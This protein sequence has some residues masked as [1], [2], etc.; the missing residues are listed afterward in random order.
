MNDQKGCDDKDDKIV[1][2]ALVDSGD[3]GAHQLAE[4]PPSYPQAQGQ[5]L[6][7]AHPPEVPTASAYP[8]QPHHT[9]APFRTLHIMYENWCMNGI[10]IHDTDKSTLLYTLKRHLRTPH[11]TL[12]SASSAAT[13]GTAILHFHTSRV[14]I[15]VN[16]AAVS[17][18]S[19]GFW[20]KSYK[21]SSPAL[22]GATVTWKCNNS[23]LD[24]VCVDEQEI[25]IARFRYSNWSLKK[26]GSFEILGPKAGTVQLT[27]EMLVTGLAL[28]VLCQRL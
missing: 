12:E 16:E 15:T 3:R 10:R 26:C 5:A 25:A 9:Q 14:D 8:P 2:K 21:W 11:L 13:V 22:E 23:N 24:L 19:H 20:Q 6:V 18:T 28:L 1:G 4:P 27:E 17:M 7:E